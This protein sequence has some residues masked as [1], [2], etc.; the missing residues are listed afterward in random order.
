MHLAWTVSTVIS[1]AVEYKQIFN[2]EGSKHGQKCEQ[3]DC[4]STCKGSKC[5][6][7]EFQVMKVHENTMYRFG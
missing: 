3:W 5:I 2:H 1:S 7:T 6:Q 4:H